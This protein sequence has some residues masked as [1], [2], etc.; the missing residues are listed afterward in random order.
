MT[1]DATHKKKP[2]INGVTE[3]SRVDLR[4]DQKRPAFGGRPIR[5]P[6]MKECVYLISN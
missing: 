2:A 6:V 3:D 4:S 5:P 1:G